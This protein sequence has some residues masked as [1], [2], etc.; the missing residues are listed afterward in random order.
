MI[1]TTA[2]IT[3]STITA[4]PWET[5]RFLGSRLRLTVKRYA[6]RV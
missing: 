2:T 4:V 5:S 3:T 1:T 6:R